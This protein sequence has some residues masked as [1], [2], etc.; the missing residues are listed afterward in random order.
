LTDPI[1]A[2][3]AAKPFLLLP[4]YYYYCAAP[5][6]CNLSLHN[7]IPVGV[8]C[9]SL[10]LTH[11]YLDT[12]AQQEQQQQKKQQTTTT[13]TLREEGKAKQLWIF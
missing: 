2:V 4:Y 5:E 8:F 3:A 1:A 7:C 10:E 13:S 11:C 9:V 6:K 12:E